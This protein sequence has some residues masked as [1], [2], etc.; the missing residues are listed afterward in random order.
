MINDFMERKDEDF[1]RNFVDYFFSWRKI[2]FPKI[3]AGGSRTNKAKAQPPSSPLGSE[4]R[5]G[6]LAQPRPI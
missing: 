1:L 3:V 5:R 4:V 6:R 2:A